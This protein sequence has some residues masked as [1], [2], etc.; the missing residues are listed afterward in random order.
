[1]PLMLRASHDVP[2]RQRGGRSALVD[3]DEQWFDASRVSKGDISPDPMSAWLQLDELHQADR[4]LA[5]ALPDGTIDDSDIKLPIPSPRSVFAVGLN[6][7]SH[8]DETQM[9]RP[10]APLVFTKFPSCLAGAYDTVLLGGTTDDYEAELVVIGHG[11][12]WIRPEDAW[13]HVGGLTVGQD[14]FDRFL[15][16][17]PNPPTSTWPS[18]ATLT[19]QSVQWSSPLTPSPTPVTS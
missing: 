13:H 12:R 18:P 6:Y 8:A 1:M 19:D 4:I 16:S 3:S 11:G 15:H 2:I 5:D 10:Q 14:I 7:Q 9:P 17:R